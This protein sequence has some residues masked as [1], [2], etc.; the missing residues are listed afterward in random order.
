MW[1]VEWVRFEELSLSDEE[2]VEGAETLNP[3]GRANRAGAW[4][5]EHLLQLSV[6]Q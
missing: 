6:Q 4:Y 5:G 3:T 2:M 1:L